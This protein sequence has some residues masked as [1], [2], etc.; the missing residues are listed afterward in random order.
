MDRQTFEELCKRLI[1]GLTSIE[2]LDG[3]LLALH[4]AMYSQEFP[5]ADEEIARRVRNAIGPNVPLMVTHDFHAN[6]PS[7]PC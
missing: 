6:I 4:G 5:H 7:G 2:G 1:D 3:V